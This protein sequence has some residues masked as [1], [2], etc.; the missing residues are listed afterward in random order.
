MEERIAAQVHK[1]TRCA[2]QQQQHTQHPVS[3][4]PVAVL[5]EAI[6]DRNILRGSSL[7]AAGRLDIVRD[8]YFAAIRF[9]AGRV[10]H[11]V[12][13]RGDIAEGYVPFVICL[14]RHRVRVQYYLFTANRLMILI[15][16]THRNVEALCD[17]CLFGRSRRD[18]L[19]VD[20]YHFV[21][22]RHTRSQE[23]R[24]QHDIV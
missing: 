4:K 13:T 3:R 14:A 21:G 16:D 11:L 8:R 24:I 7:H 10:E 2:H 12:R 18:T 15:E 6:H 20:C 5:F 19:L 1:D 9:A 17:K 22:I 23:L